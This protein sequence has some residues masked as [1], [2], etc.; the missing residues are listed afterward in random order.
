MKYSPEG[1]HIAGRKKD[2]FNTCKG[3]NIYPSRIEGILEELPLMAEA[4]LLGDRR[5]FIAALLVP[6]VS[7]VTQELGRDITEADYVQGS[8]LYQALMRSLAR[9]N[10]GLEPYECIHKIYLLKTPFQPTVQSQVGGISKTH[11]RRELVDQFY[12]TEIH[13]IYEV[14]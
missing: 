4:V 14:A 7:K 8:E 3:S 5:P 9:I 6:N 10:E 2:I 1:L 12:Q 11:V 13:P